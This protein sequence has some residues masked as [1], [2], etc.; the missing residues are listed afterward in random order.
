MF[1]SFNPTYN[2]NGIS[3]FLRCLRF[4]NKVSLV[5]TI[6]DCFLYENIISWETDKVAWLTLVGVGSAP[7]ISSEHKL[8]RGNGMDSCWQLTGKFPW[9]ELVT[10]EICL[11]IGRATFS[12]AYSR[13]DWFF[14]NLFFT[15][16]SISCEYVMVF[17]RSNLWSLNSG[18][19]SS[20]R[21]VNRETCGETGIFSDLRSSL[22]MDC[23]SATAK[24]I[25]LCMLHCSFTKCI[26]F[27]KCNSLKNFSD[28]FSGATFQGIGSHE[29]YKPYMIEHAMSLQHKD[30]TVFPISG[31]TNIVIPLNSIF[32]WSH[33]AERVFLR[34]FQ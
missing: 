23:N 7:S 32:R 13:E 34:Q 6:L 12:R 22:Y 19:T 18:R 15:R 16:W 26:V 9:K 33:F 25:F 30:W 31:K 2:G 28:R 29:R 8:K 27:R 5:C 17:L 11:W 1:I 14:F 3:R 10:S 4:A 20:K 24:E 21:S